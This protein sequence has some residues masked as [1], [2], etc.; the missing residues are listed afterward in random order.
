MRRFAREQSL[1][2]VFLVL[3]V[4]ALA[5][6]AYAGWQDYNNVETWHAQMANETP[7]TI[8]FGRYLTTSS[9]AQAVTENWQSEYLQFTLFILLTVWFIQKGSPESKR[10]GEEGGE[11]DEEQ[12]VG[13]HARD[14]SPTWARA[15][16]W[17]LALYS[18]SL[19]LVMTIIWIWSWFAQSV[20]GWSEH[21]ADLLEHEQ[22]ALSWVGYLGSADFW[23]TTLQNWQSEFLAVGSMAV[24]AIYLRQRGSPESKPVG[25]PHH[26]TSVEG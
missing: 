1:S 5:G 18:N 16:G 6:Q 4:G 19:V 21:N 8:S 24:L 13:E 17:Q 20:S 3:F 10:P 22:P 26:A 7:E 15:R 2:I 12:S 14:D 11:S 23:Q 9:F 25:A